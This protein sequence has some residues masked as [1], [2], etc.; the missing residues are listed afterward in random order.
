MSTPALLL[1]FSQTV[2]KYPPKKIENED[3]LVEIE[4]V[5]EYEAIG[6]GKLITRSQGI[7]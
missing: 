7:F 2:E 6:G 4:D 5:Q 1:N 3:E